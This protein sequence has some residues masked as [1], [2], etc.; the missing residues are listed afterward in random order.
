MAQGQFTRQEAKSVTEAL[1]EIMEAIPKSK[2]MN[3]VGHF[4]DLF[5]FLRAATAKAPSEKT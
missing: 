4:N 1:E 3:F 5:L 2:A